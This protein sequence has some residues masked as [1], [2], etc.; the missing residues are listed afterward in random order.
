MIPPTF[1]DDPSP[2]PESPP[3]A[4]RDPS[5]NGA[6]RPAAAAGITIALLLTFVGGAS[7]GR[8]AAP[9]APPAAGS[10]ATTPSAKELA[11]ISEAW[12][13]IH[14]KYVDAASLDDRKLA[15]GAI[16]GMTDAVGDTGHTS[17]LTP[18]ERQQRSSSLQGSYVGIGAELDTTATGLPRIVG[19]FKDS[20]ADKAGLKPGD[21]VMAVD[22]RPTTGHDLDEVIG[23]VRG[24]AGTQ[25]VLT[26]RAGETG[27]ER[28][29]KITRGDVHVDPVSWTVVPGTQ[30]AF[31]RLEQ[32]SNG[33][34]NE[35]VTALKAIKEAGANR[36]V[37]DL[38]GDP[39][40]YVNEAVGV[41]S[42]FLSSGDVFTERDAA[43]H[44]T[45]H[46]ASPGGAATDVPMVVLVDDGTASAAEIVAGAIQDAGRGTIVGA[47]TFGTGTVLAE[48]SLSD[49]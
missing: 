5:T 32:F 36:I 38:R 8:L 17:F 10:V 13:L 39:G 41:A 29:L 12:G 2:R 35:L 7:L 34:A 6:R 48:F 23:W 33:A 42:Q 26:V 21:V 1:P 11:L 40:G 46:P 18:E 4:W 9:E 37:F 31:L 45:H 24:E 30:T 16:D 19:V 25:V 15:Y 49:G 47:K 44:T 3:A 27:P 28:E 22:G 43:G 14:D 20:P